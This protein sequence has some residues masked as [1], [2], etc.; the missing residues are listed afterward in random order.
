MLSVPSIVQSILID[1]TKARRFHDKNAAQAGS[2]VQPAPSDANSASR[3]GR[4]LGCTAPILFGGPLPWWSYVISLQNIWMDIDQ[5]YGAS[6]LAGTWSL[7][8]EEQFYLIFPL[9]GYFASSLTVPRL[10]ILL[11]VLCPVGRMIS[12][13]LGDQF[14]YYVRHL[15][16]VRG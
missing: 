3:A 8:I 13:G 1:L 16:L 6:W 2:T 10:L 9:V 12:F 11:L 14:G 5:T 15:E 4:R 7:V